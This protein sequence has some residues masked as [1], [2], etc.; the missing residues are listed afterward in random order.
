MTQAAMIPTYTPDDLLEL[1][2]AVSYELVGGELVERNVSK[3]S[4]RVALNIGSLLRVEILRTG[5]AEVYGCDLGYACFRD[6]QEIRKPDVSVVRRERLRELKNKNPGYMPIAPDLAVEVIS[7][8]DLA[9]RLNSKLNLYL[10]AGVKLVWLVS[11]ELGTVAAYTL[12]GSYKI[13][14]ATDL[15]TAAP[16]LAN[17]SC[18]V[19]D[20]FNE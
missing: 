1:E 3:E 16:A 8:N 12:D 14:R 13:H 5:E 11:P 2:E 20:F 15:I 17:F 4:S 9:G 10:D 7:P 19:G 6:P 18:P